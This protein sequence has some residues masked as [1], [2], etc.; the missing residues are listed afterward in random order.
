MSAD[1]MGELRRRLAEA[2]RESRRARVN[3]EPYWFYLG[4]AEALRGVLEL[5]EP[6]DGALCG[7]VYMVGVRGDEHVC[8]QPAGH[9]GLHGAPE[10]P[11]DGVSDCPPVSASRGVW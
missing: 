6:P 11:A 4:R 8:G 9:G 1:A 5:L 2:E 7:E 10:T 3:S